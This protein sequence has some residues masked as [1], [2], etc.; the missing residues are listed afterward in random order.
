MPWVRLDDE[1][2]DH[3]KVAVVGVFG[4]AL[5]VAALCYAN[6]HLTDG[7]VPLQVIRRLL[8]FDGVGENN[9]TGWKEVDAWEVAERLVMA[10]IWTV[11]PKGFRI[12]NYLSYQP[13]KADVQAERL[14]QHEIKVAGGKARAAGA[15]RDRGK[16]V[17]EQANTS[18]TSRRPAAVPAGRPAENQQATSPVPETLSTVGNEGTGGRGVRGEGVAPPSPSPSGDDSATPTGTRCRH[19][20]DPATCGACSNPTP[21]MPPRAALA[22]AL[23]PSG[24][25]TP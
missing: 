14:A 11:E 4:V 12:H 9:G 7:F 15:K 17:K 3:P 10:G 23:K 18:I 16:F 8:D 19:R 6:R 20:N 1:F 2:T 22:A 24:G 5:Q 13:S 25:E 21:A